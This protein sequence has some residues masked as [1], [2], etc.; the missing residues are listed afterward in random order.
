MDSSIIRGLDLAVPPGNRHLEASHSSPLVPLRAWQSAD[1]VPSGSQA[2][3]PVLP[4]RVQTVTSAVQV[5]ETFFSD[6]RVSVAN[7]DPNAGPETSDPNISRR[8]SAAGILSSLVSKSSVLQRSIDQRVS[9][10]WLVDGDDDT[11]LGEFEGTEG[12]ARLQHNLRIQKRRM[13]AGSVLVIEDLNT[14]T[15]EA[16]GLEYP[17]LDQG[18]LVEHMIRFDEPPTDARVED[19][20]RHLPETG[21]IRVDWNRY[22]HARIE[23]ELWL[24]RFISAQDE[25]SFHLDLISSRYDRV[26][27][28]SLNVL[29]TL[30]RDRWR[31]HELRRDIFTRSVDGV[32]RKSS[33]RISCCRLPGNS[34]R[35]THLSPRTVTGGGESYWLILS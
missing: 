12:I 3:H 30:H 28:A 31:S 29:E 13:A 5:S 10:V 19:W 15:C 27:S 23:T 26:G 17:Q 11:F 25:W 35:S 24:D 1:N 6:R 14:K 33:T 34:G 21:R 7:D 20:E 18:F 4:T 2:A 32:L 16:L 8:Q 9:T 22:S